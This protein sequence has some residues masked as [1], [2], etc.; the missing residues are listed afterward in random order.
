MQKFQQPGVK[1]LAEFGSASTCAQG[2][3]EGGRLKG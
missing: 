2:D 3:G 1:V